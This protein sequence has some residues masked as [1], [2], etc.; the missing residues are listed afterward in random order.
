MPWES[1]ALLGI[2]LK[3][4]G[5]FRQWDNSFQNLLIWLPI[6]QLLIANLVFPSSGGFLFA[7]FPFKIRTVDTVGINQAAKQET[8]WAEIKFFDFVSLTAESERIGSTAFHRTARSGFSCRIHVLLQNS[9]YRHFARIPPNASIRPF[10]QTFFK[11]R[12]LHASNSQ[13]NAS[14]WCEGNTPKP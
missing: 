4:C 5:G 14:P 8:G 10:F 12:C 2:R 11:R 1:T 6:Y 9:F 13:S 3:F 7:L